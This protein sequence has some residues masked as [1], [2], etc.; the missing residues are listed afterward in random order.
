MNPLYFS[1]RMCLFT[2]HEGLNRKAGFHAFTFLLKYIQGTKGLVNCA[3]LALCGQPLF[4]ITEELISV[5]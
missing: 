1:W 2:S 5:F 3:I 4:K